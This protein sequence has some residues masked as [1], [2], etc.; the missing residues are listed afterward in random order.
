MAGL[1]RKIAKAV[2]RLELLAAW[3]GTVK[4]LGYGGPFGWLVIFQID[5]REHVERRRDDERLVEPDRQ[6]A[7]VDF[8]T[9]VNLPA[10]ALG[11]AG[12]GLTPFAVGQHLPAKAKVPLADHRRVVAVLLEKP[13]CSQPVA[14]DERFRQPPKNPLLQRAAPVVS[15]GENPVTSWGAD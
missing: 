7:A 9:V 2:Y 4:R 15:P 11:R 10:V 13:G 5:V 3:P 12:F 1:A 6:R 8:F 14:A